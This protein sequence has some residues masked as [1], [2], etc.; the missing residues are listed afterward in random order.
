MFVLLAILIA[1]ALLYVLQS[2]LVVLGLY[3]EPILRSFEVYGEERLYNPLLLLVLWSL[4]LVWLM[5]A[6][7]VDTVFALFLFVLAL[8]LFSYLDQPIKRFMHNHPGFFLR[9]PRWYG[10]LVTRANREE[11][12]RIA[13]LWLRLPLRT[14]LHYNARDEAFYQWAELVLLTINR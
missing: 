8:P 9:F 4:V 14:R 2:L 13:Y 10:E 5:I 6:I 3:K 12:R 1:V 11:R 7:F